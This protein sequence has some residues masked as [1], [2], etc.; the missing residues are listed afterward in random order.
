MVLPDNLREKF[1]KFRLKIRLWDLITLLKAFFD[2]IVG[3]NWDLNQGLKRILDYFFSFFC[4]PAQ[5]GR[6]HVDKH[7][8]DDDDDHRQHQRGILR[9]DE[10]EKNLLN[11]E[12]RGCDT[13]GQKYFFRF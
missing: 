6:Q 7:V 4:R 5:K 8:D 2:E 9:L 10:S 11:I 1:N 13:S 12:V 3:N